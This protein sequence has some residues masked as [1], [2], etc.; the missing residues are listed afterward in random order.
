MKHERTNPVNGKKMSALAQL[1]ALLIERGIATT[2]ALAEETGY[3]E[4]QI[5][6]A[7]KEINSSRAETVT[8]T[9]VSD[10]DVRVDEMSV[11]PMSVSVTPMSA[12][13]LTPVS[14]GPRAPA[15]KES[16]RDNIIYYNTPLT[17]QDPYSRAWFEKGRLVLADDLRAFWLERFG[18]DAD[19]LD[20]ALTQAEGWIQPNNRSRSLETQLSSQLAR[21]AADK[22]DRD[23]RY[24]AAAQAKTARPSG[25]SMLELLDEMSAKYAGGGA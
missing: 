12:S 18:G 8:D 7:K 9:N 14:A 3:S 25:A 19:R 2:K 21:I 5:W 17:P 4:R 6:R 22:R 20:L 1:C 24:A 11:T 13:T 10:T 23:A 15:C 16:L